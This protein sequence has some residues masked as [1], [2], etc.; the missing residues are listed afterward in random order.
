MVLLLTQGPILAVF[1]QASLA[2]SAI[3]PAAQKALLTLKGEHSGG[4]RAAAE[5]RHENLLL[6]QQNSA[7]M[8]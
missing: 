7:H 1:L 6:H 8:T 5:E 2:L 3:F 4:W